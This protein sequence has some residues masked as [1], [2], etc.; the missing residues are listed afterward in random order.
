MSNGDQEI[1][2]ENPENEIGHL[3][4]A[5]YNLPS[6]SRDGYYPKEGYQAACKEAVRDIIGRMAEI[7]ESRLNSDLSNAQEVNKWLLKALTKSPS[8]RPLSEDDRRNS[9]V[10]IFGNVTAEIMRRVA[11]LKKE[12]TK[13]SNTA[14]STQQLI[15]D[16]N[17]RIQKEIG[18]YHM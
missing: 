4:D 11:K 5:L 3:F 6:A 2:L 7:T 12:E 9:V 14:S 13:E 18:N 8:I 17:R 1:P 15:Q 10:D 16:V